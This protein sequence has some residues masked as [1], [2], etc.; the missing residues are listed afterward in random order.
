[1]AALK[2]TVYNTNTEVE[3][4]PTGSGEVYLDGE[5]NALSVSLSDIVYDPEGTV[6]GYY[7]KT[8]GGSWNYNYTKI[9][10]KRV[11][12]SIDTSFSNYNGTGANDTNVSGSLFYSFGVGGTTGITY[13]VRLAVQTM[14][15]VWHYSNV[16]QYTHTGEG[17][18]N[19]G[20]GCIFYDYDPTCTPCTPS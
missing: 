10:S 18:Y 9:I 1:M 19:C 16:I 20:Y 11:Q 12:W 8:V 2:K 15:N 6:R 7:A 14:D 5:N 3:F 4:S 17:Y 13:N